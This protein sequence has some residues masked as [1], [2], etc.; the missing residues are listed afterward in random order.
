MLESCGQLRTAQGHQ[1]Q[2]L[3]AHISAV[4]SITHP[5]E[6]QDERQTEGGQEEGGQKEEEQEE[7]DDADDV[8]YDRSAETI[9]ENMARLVGGHC[10][11]A[12][13]ALVH[14]LGHF[15]G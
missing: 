11:N 8:G 5:G 2:L 1:L 7:E 10:S 14:T 6:P 4:R 15:D 13:D 3:F 9:R 12:L